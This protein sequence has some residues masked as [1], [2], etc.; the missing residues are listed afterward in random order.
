[1]STPHPDAIHP[2][3][4]IVIHC[5]EVK[6]IRWPAQSAGMVAVQRYQTASMKSVWPDAND[7][8]DSGQKG[9]RMRSFRS[10]LIRPRS[11]PL[12]PWSISNCHSPL[13]QSHFER[14]N[15]GRGIWL[16]VWPSS[17]SLL[18]NMFQLRK[19]S[20]CKLSSSPSIGCGSST[21]AICCTMT[22]SSAAIC[23][24]I[25]SS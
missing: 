1:M 23:S 11:R 18:Q 4:C 20:S 8:D 9:T 5:L 17:M 6:R 22:F 16:V 15:C 14:T 10:R 3:G 24:R 25:I 12:S 19:C 7:N 13:R 21:R 2:D